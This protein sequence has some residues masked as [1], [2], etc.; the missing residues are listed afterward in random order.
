MMK[1]LV[2]WMTNSRNS[3]KNQPKQLLQLMLKPLLLL[4]LL[5][6]KKVLL[7]KGQWL[8]ISEKYVENKCKYK[9][10]LMKKEYYIFCPPQFS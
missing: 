8:M 7:P 2:E 4:K 9:K 6:N 3:C 10:I 1:K 5:L